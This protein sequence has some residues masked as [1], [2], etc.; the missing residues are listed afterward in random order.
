MPFMRQYTFLFQKQ[1]LMK[2]GEM[3]KP[4]IG[5]A[6]TKGCC[7]KC[8]NC[9]NDIESKIPSVDDEDIESRRNKHK[10]SKESTSYDLNKDEKH[11]SFM[12]RLHKF[13]P[14]PLH[15]HSLLVNQIVAGMNR[16]YE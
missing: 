3:V 10:K 16:D 1:S 12:E 7:G 13:K 8:K 15:S 4:A 5:F 2:D 11:S 14:T 9:A 6:R